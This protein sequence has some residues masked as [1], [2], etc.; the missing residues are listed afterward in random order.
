MDNQRSPPR[1]RSRSPSP[2]SARAR[3]AR[4]GP[5]PGDAVWVKEV[6]KFDGMGQSIEAPQPPEPVGGSTGLTVA[7]WVKRSSDVGAYDRLIDFGNG[8]EK[9]NIVINF[10]QTTMYEVRCDGVNQTLVVDEKSQ[11]VFPMDQWVHVALVHDTDGTASIFWNGVCKASGP[12]WLPPPVHREK[13]YVGRSHWGHDPY[14]KGE[15]SDVH[16][17]NYALDRDEIRRCCFSRMLP[18]QQRGPPI[19]SLAADW[20]WAT[21]MSMKMAFTHQPTDDECGFTGRWHQRRECGCEGCGGVGRCGGGGGEGGEALQFSTGLQPLQALQALNQLTQSFAR[22]REEISTLEESRDQAWS[23][24]QYG[25]AHEMNQRVNR[26]QDAL[27]RAQAVVRCERAAHAGR[28]AEAEG[29]GRD[30]LPSSPPPS[31]RACSPA[32]PHPL[33]SQARPRC[34]SLTLA[35]PCSPPPGAHLGRSG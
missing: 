30:G 29:S 25:K 32:R 28:H 27:R 14:F 22:Q 26:S 13:Y 35:L 7:A 18:R 5:D 33:R 15:I 34:F 3:T 2:G 12:V 1:L 31:R 24:G 6:M 21:K 16:V 8:A 10:Q 19:L 20:R 4:T 11:S 9:E 17:F 23:C